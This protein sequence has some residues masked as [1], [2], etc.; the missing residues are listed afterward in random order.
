MSLESFT[1][2][3][4]FHRETESNW[5]IVDIA[6]GRDY[7]NAEDLAFLGYEVEMDVEIF[8]VGGN[9]VKTINGVD[10]SHLEIYI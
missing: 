7:A 3:I 1:H 9:K 8:K 2:K 4:Y 5:E 6:E 10:V